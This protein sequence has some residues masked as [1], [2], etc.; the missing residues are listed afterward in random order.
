MIIYDHH[1]NHVKLST[2]D[3]R[4]LCKFKM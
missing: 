1:K 3:Y 2:A 4:F